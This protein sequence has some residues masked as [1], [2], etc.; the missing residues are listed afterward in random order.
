[1]CLVVFVGVLLLLIPVFVISLISQKLGLIV[2]VPLILIPLFI[3]SFAWMF[4]PYIVVDRGLGPMRSLKESWRI[5]K[6]TGGGFFLLW[7]GVG[8]RHS[9][10]SHRA[11]RRPARRPFRYCMLALVHAYRFLQSAAG[12]APA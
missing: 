2:G 1:M 10:R 9:A 6:A 3:V 12:P 4:V 5:T 11:Y 7:L 8:R